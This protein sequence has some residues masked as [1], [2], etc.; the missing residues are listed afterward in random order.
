MGNATASVVGHLHAGEIEQD[1]PGRVEKINA[2]L[3]NCSQGLRRNKQQLILGGSPLE[4]LG[5]LD[6]FD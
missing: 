6:G 2:G 5:G 4:G 1:R 3:L